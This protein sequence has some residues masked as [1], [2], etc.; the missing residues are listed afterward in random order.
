MREAVLI[1]NPASGR[2]R[3]ARLV[4]SVTLRLEEAGVRVAARGTR[5]P[6]DAE[7]LVAEATAECPDAAILALGG[8]GTLNEV[9]SGLHSVGRLGDRAPLVGV[10]PAGTTNVIARD[11][12][13]PRDPLAA[14]RVV[15]SGEPRPFD[16]GLSESSVGVR[17]FLLACGV[18]F[19]ARVAERVPTA[20]KRLFGRHAYTLAGLRETGSPAAPLAVEL[21]REDGSREEDAAAAWVV[22]GNARL[23]GG[24]GLLSRDAAHDDGLLDVALVDSTRLLPLLRAAWKATHSEMAAAPGVRVVRA[25]RVSVRCAEPVPFHVDAEPGGTTPVRMSVLRHGLRLLASPERPA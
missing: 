13:L 1:Y 24:T 8:D 4:R 25:R 11:L 2:G 7:R 19:D 12:G 5:G 20:W 6:A 15:A 3:G 18:G 10:I 17:P 16:V 14:A 9:V 21:E 23:Y 22:A